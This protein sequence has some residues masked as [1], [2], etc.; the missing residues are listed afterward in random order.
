MKYFYIPSD[1]AKLL[2]MH[3]IKQDIEQ[4]NY[5]E[6]NMEYWMLYSLFSDFNFPSLSSLSP[7]A[8]AKNVKLRLHCE[9]QNVIFY[10]RAM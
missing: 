8:S 3:F 10:T 7:S 9:M 2:E 5:P 6:D 4:K 1:G